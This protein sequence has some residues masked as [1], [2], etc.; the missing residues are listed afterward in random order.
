MIYTENT[1]D[2]YRLSTSDI[3]LYISKKT[4]KLYS[5]HIDY[6]IYNNYEHKIYIIHLYFEIYVYMYIVLIDCIVYLKLINVFRDII[7]L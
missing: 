2:R 3:H 4:K 5:N 1:Y 7:T 6:Y